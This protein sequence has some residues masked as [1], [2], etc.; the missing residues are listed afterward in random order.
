M[1]RPVEI[2]ADTVR[3]GDQLMIGGQAFTVQDMTA[4]RGGAKRL[5]FTSGDSFILR[6]TTVLWASRRMAPQR[7]RRGA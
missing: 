2:N 7:L 3:R 1:S 6:R 4:I 5:E